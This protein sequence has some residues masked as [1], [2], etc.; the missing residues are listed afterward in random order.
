MVQSSMA[1]RVEES[2]LH[3]RVTLQSLAQH[4]GLST[5]TVS[6]VVNDAPAAPGI[7]RKTRERILEAAE[8]LKSRPN[9]LAR[10]LRGTRSMSVGILAPETSEGYLTLV[11]Y[12][13]E[14][15]LLNAH[16]LFYKAS[17]H[18]QQAL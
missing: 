6:V 17:H 12:G 9:Y 11:M 15:H 13:V 7:P 4:L 3:K 18:H 16:Y 14:Q 8:T 2:P 10:S 5:T 1:K